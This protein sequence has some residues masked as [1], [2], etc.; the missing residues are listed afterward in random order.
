MRDLLISGAQGLPVNSRFLLARFV[1]RRNDNDLFFIARLRHGL[2][3]ALPVSR[4]ANMLE[5]PQR[6][7]GLAVIALL[8]DGSG[9]SENNAA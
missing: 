3:R 5:N 6:L 8:T 2:S 1:A 4:R 9:S 7:R